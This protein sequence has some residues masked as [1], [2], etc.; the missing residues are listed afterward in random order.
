MSRKSEETFRPGRWRVHTVLVRG[1]ESGERGEGPRLVG[2][3]KASISGD[4][5]EAEGDNSF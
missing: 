2:V 4:R 5:G 1:V 3:Q